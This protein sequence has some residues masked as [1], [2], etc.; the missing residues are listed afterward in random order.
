MVEEA[1]RLTLVAAFVI[2]DTIPADDNVMRGTLFTGLLPYSQW[3]LGYWIDSRLESAWY[4]LFPL[5]IGDIRLCLRSVDSRVPW[6]RLLSW[7]LGDD[8]V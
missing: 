4:R 3:P 6:D 7:V 8:Y 1:R 2:Y 5:D